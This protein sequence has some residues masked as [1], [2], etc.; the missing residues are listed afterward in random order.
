MSRSRSN[1][2]PAASGDAIG[3]K[4]A[5][6]DFL[7]YLQRKGDSGSHLREVPQLLQVGGPSK[8]VSG[9]CVSVNRQQA[10]PRLDF[11]LGIAKRHSARERHAFPNG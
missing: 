5:V 7:L 11:R 8:A 3:I 6:N 9:P 4:E 10:K 2:L 1:R